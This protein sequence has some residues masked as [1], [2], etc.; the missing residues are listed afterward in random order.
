[1]A[2]DNKQFNDA[3]V[4]Y[5]EALDIFKMLG[6]FDQADIL[7]REI[8]HVEIYK[9]E[10]LKKQSFEDQKRQ[11]REELFQKRVD[12]LLEEQSQKKS[13]IRANLMKLPPEIRKIIDKINLL[14]EKAE[15][16][17]TAQI[18]ERALNRY[19]YILELYRSIPPDKLNLTEEIA[20][21]NQK[22]EDLKVKY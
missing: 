5:K 8:Q 13:L 3:K 7:Y 2:I 1:M 9:T 4:F 22:I 18:Y 6:W 17:V 19:E 10:F 21:I 15:K 11:K 16:E 20:E 14:I 12:A